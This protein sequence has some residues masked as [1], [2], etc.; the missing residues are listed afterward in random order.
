MTTE[1]LLKQED[2]VK[3][4]LEEYPETRDDD[5]LL[6]AAVIE[7][8]RPDLQNLSVIDFLTMHKDLYCPSYESVSRVRRRLQNKYPELASE[9]AKARRSKQEAE[10]RAYAKEA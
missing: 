8:C 5:F 6:Y 4:I 1:K 10:Y 3:P 7:K 2:I 9:R